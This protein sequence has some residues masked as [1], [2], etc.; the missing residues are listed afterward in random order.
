M[1]NKNNKHKNRH[2]TK[3]FCGPAN[4]A[5]PAELHVKQSSWAPLYRYLQYTPPPRREFCST[6]GTSA[7]TNYVHIC[8]NL[9]RATHCPAI[10][11][12]SLREVATTASCTQKRWAPCRSIVPWLRAQSRNTS[13]SVPLPIGP[14]AIRFGASNTSVRRAPCT[15]RLPAPCH[16]DLRQWRRY[17]R[18]HRRRPAAKRLTSTTILTYHSTLPKRSQVS[19]TMRI[20]RTW[21]TS[22]SKCSARSPRQRSPSHGGSSGSR[23]AT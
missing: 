10:G 19:S 17:T 20:L 22:A 8:G 9:F 21:T 3:R 12:L 23:A 13:W 5:A 7:L 11:F 2:L 16:Q 18:R 6:W 1:T 4:S 14:V 15:Y